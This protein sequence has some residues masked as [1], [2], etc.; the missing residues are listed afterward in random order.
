MKD[1]RCVTIPVVWLG[2]GIRQDIEEDNKKRKAELEQYIREGFEVKLITS[3][4]VAD[5]MYVF[6]YLEREY[7]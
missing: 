7:E 3:S 4:T 1:I 6:H 5:I 2:A